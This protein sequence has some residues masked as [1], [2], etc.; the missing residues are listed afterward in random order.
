MKYIIIF[1]LFISG[2][3]S[4]IDTVTVCKNSSVYYVADTVGH[5]LLDSNWEWQFYGGYPN[6]FNG[7]DTTP[8]ILYKNVGYFL[9]V[10]KT[11]FYGG[12]TDIDTTIIRVY[13]SYFDPILLK[14]TFIC[15]PNLIFLTANNNYPGY[16]HKW[17]ALNGNT[18][19][20]FNKSINIKDTGFYKIIIKA[21]CGEI[22]K[23]IRVSNK[24]KP[25][26]YIPNSFTPNDDGLNNVY[27][28]YIEG[29][30]KY[31]MII[32]NRWGEILFESTDPK[33]GWDGTYL[34]KDCQQDVYV[35]IFY[36]L[37]DFGPQLE[38]TLVFLLK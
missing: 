24:C 10:C 26:L 9:T 5:S 1:L 3:V 23:T 25:I 11:T 13:E 8:N 19:P 35:A 27:K 22:E 12:G 31:R 37:S 32:F 16:V 18:P 17:F 2:T 29:Y 4:A 21:S 38:K 14:D 33:I 30:S 6:T 20:E 7:N 34:K 36:L 28:P 15:S